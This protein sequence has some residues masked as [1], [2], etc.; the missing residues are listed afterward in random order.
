MPRI[1]TFAIFFSLL[2]SSSVLA[3]DYTWSPPP[4]SGIVCGACCNAD[5]SCN[6]PWDCTTTCSG[7]CS[8][9]WLPTGVPGPGDTVT[10]GGTAS[11]A[12][13]LETVQGLTLTGNIVLSGGG[14]DLS[15]RRDLLA[16]SRRSLDLRDHTRL[17]R[18]ASSSGSHRG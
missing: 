6:G 8:Q 12:T 1:A 18:G 11:I 15:R 3:T 9:G 4:C 14:I 13:E 10:I 7:P 5:G 16:R 17:P 2:V